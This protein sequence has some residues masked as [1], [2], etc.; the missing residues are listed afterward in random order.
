MILREGYHLA[1]LYAF[2]VQLS[3]WKYYYSLLFYSYLKLLTKSL[4][5]L[6]ATIILYINFISKKC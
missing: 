2:Y 6:S 4:Y 1:I 3:I 5:P